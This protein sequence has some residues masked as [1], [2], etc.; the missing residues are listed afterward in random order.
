MY[1]ANIMQCTSGYHNYICLS[2]FYFSFVHKLHANSHSV[3]I[4]VLPQTFAVVK[5]SKKG[6]QGMFGYVFEMPCEPIDL[7][8]EF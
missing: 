6:K 8:S 5:P 2:K 7:I 4:F 1:T 3:K